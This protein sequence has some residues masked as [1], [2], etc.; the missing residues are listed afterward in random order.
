[1]IKTLFKL[2]LFFVL[3]PFNPLAA[4][5]I[6]QGSAR[7]VLKEIGIYEAHKEG[8]TGK[9]VGILVIDDFDKT[10]KIGNPHG[11]I[12]INFIKL[13]APNAPIF[14]LQYQVFFNKGIGE[15]AQKIEDGTIKIV[16]FSIG[17]SQYFLETIQT[18]QTINILMTAYKIVEGLKP[19]FEHGATVLIGAGNESKLLGTSKTLD[20]YFLMQMNHLKARGSFLFVGAS[21]PGSKDLS[22]SQM[23]GTYRN[24]YVHLPV[25]G[26][27]SQTNKFGKKFERVQG[28]SIA[29]PMLS[30]ILALLVEKYPN[31]S[32]Q[33]VTN[34]IKYSSESN[35]TITKG[36]FDTLEITTNLSPNHRKA[37]TPEDI[38]GFGVPNL[39]K[40]IKIK[41]SVKLDITPTLSEKNNSIIQKALYDAKLAPFYTVYKKR[42]LANLNPAQADII[43]TEASKLFLKQNKKYPLNLFDTIK[44]MD[45]EKNIRPIYRSIL[46]ESLY[47]LENYRSSKEYHYKV[48]HSLL[49]ALHAKLEKKIKL[50]EK[51]FKTYYP[52]WQKA[53]CL[54]FHLYPEC[55]SYYETTRKEPYNSTIPFFPFSEKIATRKVSQPPK[56]APETILQK[57]RKTK[58]KPDTSWIRQE[59]TK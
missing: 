39:S 48:W 52:K 1:M 11:E 37:L 17:F 50:A 54:L 51:E 5:E 53:Y 36:V 33:Q 6:S 10:G 44:I 49:I 31:L 38:Y 23:A 46:Q 15:Y 13:V 25:Q 9:D 18:T 43:L 3:L 4:S 16:N 45:T 30:G 47:L 12:V 35:K 26:I 34:L 41:N 14:K 57:P 40:S 42:S 8:I 7:P 22:N 29:A 20:A 27:V 56:K 21:L 19:A 59:K 32:A 58:I 28:T 24:H 55:K 2:F